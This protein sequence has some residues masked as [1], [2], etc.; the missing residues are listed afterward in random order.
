MLMDEFIAILAW[1]G[2]SIH[3]WMIVMLIVVVGL[4]E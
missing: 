2:G 1:I 3:I 4:V